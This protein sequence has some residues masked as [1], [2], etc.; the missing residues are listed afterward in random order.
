MAWAGA[1]GLGQGRVGHIL[2]FPQTVWTLL[3]ELRAP[4]LWVSWSSLSC[5]SQAPGQQLGSAASRTAKAGSRLRLTALQRGDGL[6]CFLGFLLL[7]PMMFSVEKQMPAQQE[8]PGMMC[9]QQ[10]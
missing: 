7:E 6:R 9:A 2:L 4:A 5:T 10:G 3:G 1:L 8:L